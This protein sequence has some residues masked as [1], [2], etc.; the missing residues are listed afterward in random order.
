M[1]VPEI[2]QRYRRAMRKEEIRIGG[3][4]ELEEVMVGGGWEVMP[5]GVG[6]DVVN[7]LQTLLLLVFLEA[8]TFPG[9]KSDSK[10]FLT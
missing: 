5:E 2:K 1:N 3:R 7:S 9:R 4:V 6:R 10:L 8:S